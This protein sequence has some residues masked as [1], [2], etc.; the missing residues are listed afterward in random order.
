MAGLHSRKGCMMID[1]VIWAQCINM[2]DTQAD[3]HVAMAALTQ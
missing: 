1:S 3:S 2:T